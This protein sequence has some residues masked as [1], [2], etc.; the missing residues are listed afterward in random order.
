MA[1]GKE[2]ISE[3]KF[4]YIFPDDY[5]PIYVNGI[6]G[7][8]TPNG[9]IVANFFFERHALPNSQS[10]QLM[11]NGTLGELVSNEPEDLQKSMVRV[12]NSGVILNVR[13]AKELHRWLGEQLK[14][15]EKME[16]ESK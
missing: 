7:G 6:Y 5:N 3:I 8:V 9:D 1:K 14:I 2:K 12:V 16:K 11:A 4:K 13:T 10:Q 15:A